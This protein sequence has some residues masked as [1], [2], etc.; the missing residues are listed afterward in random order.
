MFFSIQYSLSNHSLRGKSLRLELQLLQHIYIPLSFFVPSEKAAF[1]GRL[2]DPS[3]GRQLPRWSRSI[4]YRIMLNHV[5]HQPH[6]RHPLSTKRA[7]ARRPKVKVE[8]F[9]HETARNWMAGSG[10]G[11][12]VINV[13][14]WAPHGA[15]WMSRYVSRS[16]YA[17][18]CH[19]L[20]LN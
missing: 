18:A 12:D 10:S 17:F 3:E 19:L 9:V 4:M 1:Y 6:L 13:L 8:R 14:L 16:E 11:R 7:A 2:V 20:L 5:Q 15:T